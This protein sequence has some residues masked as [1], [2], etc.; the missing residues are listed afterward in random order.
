M[1]VALSSLVLAQESQ[2]AEL[3][4]TGTLRFSERGPTCRKYRAGCCRLGK[5]KGHVLCPS[6]LVLLRG[7]GSGD[8]EVPKLALLTDLV[9]KCCQWVTV[10][11][12]DC[13]LCILRIAREIGQ[14]LKYW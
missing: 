8:S 2:N 5:V 6:E 14:P 7:T 1:L 13:G 4:L 9:A 11:F 12:L 3:S 10:F